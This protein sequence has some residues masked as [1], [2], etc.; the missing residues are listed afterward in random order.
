MSLESAAPSAPEGRFRAKWLVW[1]AIA[2]VLAGF[3]F[4]NRGEWHS[5]LTAARQANTRYL[6]LAALLQ[7]LWLTLF[8][9]SYW[10]GLRAVG[11]R[12]PFGRTMPIAWA[13]NS[14][15]MLVKSG[16]MGGIALFIR[17]GGR[18]GYTASRVTLGY[19]LVLSLG[20][21]E[22]LLILGGAMALLW[23]HGG[24][25][26]VE[27]IG[28]IFTFGAVTLALGGLIAVL[29][30]E[31]RVQRAYGLVARSVNRAAGWAR[32]GPLLDA[33]GGTRAAA[34][35][36]DVIGTVRDAPGRLVAPIAITVSKELCAIAIFYAVLRAFDPSATL[37]LA[38]IAYALAILF[39]YVSILPSGL[40]VV[41]L[42]LTALLV[43]SGVPAGAA[44]LITV[45][46][47]LFEFWT[48]FLVGGA[49]ARFAGGPKSLA[50]VAALNPSGEAVTRPPR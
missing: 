2:L 42:S 26:R 17:E 14:V 31:K 33:Q 1:L 25:Q 28:A 35:I 27:I 30:S 7:A 29:Q 43:R 12:F 19:L 39:S 41:E 3:L 48:P 8:S 49:A 24:V 40:G 36:Q 20:H 32:R 23:L 45:V 37:W 50:A 15:N 18:R 13:S 38:A 21:A 9:A 46:Y 11:V 34:E 10:S 47:R 5:M 22:F 44:T 4:L 6:A 16:G